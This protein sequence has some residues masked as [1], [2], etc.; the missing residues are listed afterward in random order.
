MAAEGPRASAASFL[1]SLSSDITAQ[2]LLGKIR[3]PGDMGE[4]RLLLV[5]RMLCNQFKSTL[6]EENYQKFI[7]NLKPAM[8]VLADALF[9]NI[10]GI[11]SP[12]TREGL[13]KLDVPLRV[14]VEQV[15]SSLTGRAEHDRGPGPGRWNDDLWIIRHHIEFICN[16][17]ISGITPQLI[18][19]GY[20]GF[21]HAVVDHLYEY[22]DVLVT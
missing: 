22:R 13:Q 2:Y 15:V 7:A 1:L 11:R 14:A 8:H 3:F 18:R 5:L 20:D 17:S 16:S 10:V 19:E 6:G 4:P 9:D 21:V 12:K